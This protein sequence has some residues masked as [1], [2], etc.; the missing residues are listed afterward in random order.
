MFPVVFGYSSFSFSVQWRR[1][2]A[3]YNHP[4]FNLSFEEGN[5]HDFALYK[6]TDELDFNANPELIQP[7][8]LPCNDLPILNEQS[9]ALMVGW[10][11]DKAKLQQA[12]VDTMWFD[13]ESELMNGLYIVA[14]HADERYDVREAFAHMIY[15]M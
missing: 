9:E 4:G 14:Q 1:V 15:F 6:L 3:I 5:G 10:S 11:N 7:V 8:C 2:E 13:G 12:H